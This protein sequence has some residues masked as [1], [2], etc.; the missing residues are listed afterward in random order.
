MAHTPADVFY[1]ISHY[2]PLHD[3]RSWRD[4]CSATR[5]V[6]PVIH[7]DVGKVTDHLKLYFKDVESFRLKCLA[8]IECVIGGMVPFRV[9]FGLPP[10]PTAVLDI[11]VTF[12]QF[13]SLC[14][15]LEKQGCTLHVHATGTTTPNDLD[16]WLW[17]VFDS[18]PGSERPP[19]PRVS[20][21]AKSGFTTPTQRRYFGRERPTINPLVISVTVASPVGGWIHIHALK[22]EYPVHRAVHAMPST[23]YLNF[24]TA[25]EIY[26]FAFEQTFRRGTHVPFHKHISFTPVQWPPPIPLHS[27]TK[28]MLAAIPPH[29]SFFGQ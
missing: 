18:C 27:V 11:F 12:Y 29:S 20:I 23:A 6:V 3:K 4:V 2:L 1:E 16:A 17:D 24:I 9:L 21:Q 25:D 13:E 10:S 15:E 19:Q 26:S 5:Q 7:H 14:E 8:D 28:E 22:P